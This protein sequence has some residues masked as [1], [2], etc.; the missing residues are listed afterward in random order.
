MMIISAPAGS[1][2]MRRTN[3]PQ[4]LKSP[5]EIPTQQYR[6]RSQQSRDPALELFDLDTPEK[7]LRYNGSTSQ[8]HP[9]YPSQELRDRSQTSSYQQVNKSGSSQKTL[10][11][12]SFGVFSF[13]VLA[14][15]SLHLINLGNHIDSTHAHIRR[16]TNVRSYPRVQ[17]QTFFMADYANKDAPS[18][19]PV[20]GR[21]VINYNKSE[22]TDV[23]QLY[24]KKSSDDTVIKDTME[25]KYFPLHETRGDAC[26]QMSPWQSMSFPT[27]NNLHEMGFV[28]SLEDT[29]LRLLSSSGSWRDAWRFKAWVPFNQR[30]ILQNVILKTIKFEHTLQD[31]YFEHSRVDAL[32]MERLTSSRYVM[33]IHGFCGMSVVTE[34]GT[35][36]IIHFV[37]HLSSSRDKVDL[38]W[39]VAQS[40]AS[41]HEIDGMNTTVS[42]VHNDINDGNI[43]IGRKNTPLLND[44]NIAVLMMKDRNTNQSCSF[45]GH[46]P[47]PQVC[48]I[49]GELC[50]ILD[51]V[52]ES[53]LTTYIFHYQW[54]S[55]EEQVGPDGNA[56]SEIT[57]KV[58]I[59]ALGNLLFRFATGKAPWREMADNSRDA[60]LTQEQKAHIVQLKMKGK[61]PKIPEEVLKLKSKDP[62]INLL[63]KAMEM[64]Y[65]F[66]PKER[67]TAREVVDFLKAGKK[68]VDDHVEFGRK[69][70]V[71]L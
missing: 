60:K 25:M 68:D 42:L 51:M 9:K 29:S 37:K 57:E 7:Q 56:N 54:K 2:M 3:K 1:V 15:A 18:F 33:N 27:C 17:P 40:V 70:N 63:L 13:V 45:P 6:P 46:Y 32:S 71:K 48:N 52:T 16:R 24:D 30:Q 8:S 41:V 50:M 58:D 4:K 21:K 38:A 62:Y 23:T 61:T 53:H 19:E 22:V 43:F 14:V 31:R 49:C 20:L 11:F 35:D 5:L 12:T 44:F 65:R 26:V 66:N 47:N 28:S 67:P 55:Y 34:R 39:K 10:P 36:D 69:V 59:Y 64:C